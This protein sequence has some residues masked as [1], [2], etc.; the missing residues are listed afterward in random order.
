MH[1]VPPVPIKKY[2]DYVGEKEFAL[3][4]VGEMVAANILP[5]VVVDDCNDVSWSHTAR[6]FKSQANLNNV[7]L[8]RGHYNSYIAKSPIR[9]RPL[10]HYFVTH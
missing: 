8:G 5:D 2:P 10:D 3:V 1:P 7:R 9:R 4:K 6:L